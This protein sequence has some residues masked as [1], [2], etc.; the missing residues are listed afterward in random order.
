M[1]KLVLLVLL[2]SACKKER[3]L[4]GVENWNVNR[5][6]LKNATGRCT[7]D[8][9]GMYC[10]GQKPMGIRGMVV[11]IDLYFAGTDPDAKLR[12]IQM[13]VAVCDDQQLYGWM[14]SNFGKPAEDKGS[15]KLWKNDFLWAV[16]DMPLPGDPGCLVRLIP[17]REQERFERAWGAA[18]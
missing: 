16:G 15:R 8:G 14:Q 4:S 12:E 1:K 9:D 13:K 3:Q 10:F 18:P 6:T 7:P 11:D 2:L 5:T 17:R